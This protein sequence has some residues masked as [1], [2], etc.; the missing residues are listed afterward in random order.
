[1]QISSLIEAYD[2][3]SSKIETTKKRLREEL[4]SD[5]NARDQVAEKVM[6][7][8]RKILHNMDRNESDRQKRVRQQNDADEAELAASVS[9][10]VVCND[11]IEL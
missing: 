4:D 9:S 6:E 1:M 5:E 10:L 8:A 3:L 2:E 11:K 7:F